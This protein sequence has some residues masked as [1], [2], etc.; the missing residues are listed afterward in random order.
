MRQSERTL[1]LLKPVLTFNALGKIVG[2]PMSREDHAQNRDSPISEPGIDRGSLPRV[3]IKAVKAQNHIRRLSS[4][5]ALG[6]KEVL[7]RSPEIV[8]PAPDRLQAFGDTKRKKC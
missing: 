7:L 8:R 1:G 6:R 3:H 5:K 4:V 2:H